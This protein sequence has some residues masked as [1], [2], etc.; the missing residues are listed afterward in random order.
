MGKVGESYLAKKKADAAPNL[1]EEEMAAKIHIKRQSGISLNLLPF[2]VWL[3]LST[4]W[5]IAEIFAL[6]VGSFGLGVYLWMSYN[7]ARGSVE[8]EF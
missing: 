5:P 3:D 7:F 4:A 1:R 8:F 6:L 2:I